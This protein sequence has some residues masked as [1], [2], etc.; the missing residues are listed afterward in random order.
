MAIVLSSVVYHRILG[1]TLLLARKERA[2]MFTKSLLSLACLVLTLHA[3]ADP[4]GGTARKF[5]DTRDGIRVF[6]D[7]LPS[8][9]TEAQWRF[10]ATHYVGSQKEKRSW[11][12]QMRQ[13]NPNFL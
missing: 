2:Q 4:I 12:R 11:T 7:Q 3:A 13:L 8:Q 9:M 6:V 1:R 5:P 10:A